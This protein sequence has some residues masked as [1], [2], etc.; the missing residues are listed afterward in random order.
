MDNKELA[1]LGW[2]VD[3]RPPMRFSIGSAAFLGGAGPSSCF[4]CGQDCVRGTWDICAPCG[5]SHDNC[6]CPAVDW[7]A[8]QLADRAFADWDPT[9]M[10]AKEPRGV[11]T[12][13]LRGYP[14]GDD[15]DDD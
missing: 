1:R 4:S 7:K 13:K 11:L 5:N 10:R 12:A 6:H 3:T 8:R 14:W 15:D 9:P 2:N